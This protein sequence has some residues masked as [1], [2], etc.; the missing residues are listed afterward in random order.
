MKFSSLNLGVAVIL[1]AFLMGCEQRYDL[2]P[3]QTPAAADKSEIADAGK[4]VVAPS[5]APM[6][7]GIVIPVPNPT[8]TVIPVPIPTSSI[9]PNPLPTPS[10]SPTPYVIPNAIPGENVG[11]MP[12]L[13]TVLA[14]SGSNIAV[15]GNAIITGNVFLL[16]PSIM[17][18]GGTSQ[19]LDGSIYMDGSSTVAVS[20]SGVDASQLVHTDMSAAEMELNNYINAL[21]SLAPTQSFSSIS[22]SMAIN[23]NGKLNV[24]SV[25]GDVSLN[26][27][28]ALVL[29]GSASDVFVIN[30]AG[31]INIQGHGSI[32]LS[33]GVLAKNVAFNALGTGAP[34]S[35][36]GGGAIN[37]TF[38]GM[39][40]SASVGGNGTLNGSLYAGGLINI[41][42]GGQAW[43]PVI[44]CSSRQSLE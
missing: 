4:G 36:N 25:G 8:G 10:V 19:L 13:A 15:T 24:I 7:P 5:P 35:L 31:T 16:D 6:A 22:S 20:T 28:T 41:S 44:F 21:G 18:I 30:L 37:G 9:S 39:S 33:G 14:F 40:R 3:L 38:I 11:C 34:L 32:V 27:Q 2:A 29:N 23:G 12:T 42:G 1:L 43:S 17:S 26:S